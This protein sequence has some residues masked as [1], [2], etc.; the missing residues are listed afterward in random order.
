[1]IQRSQIVPHLV[2]AL[3]LSGVVA[4]GVNPTSVDAARSATARS[5]KALEGGG[6]FPIVELAKGHVVQGGRN[7]ILL[8]SAWPERGE[9][10]QANR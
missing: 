3:T 4:D 10:K 1:M 8:R 5:I 2:V 6:E 7:G 9:P